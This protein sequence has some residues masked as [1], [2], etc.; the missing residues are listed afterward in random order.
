MDYSVDKNIKIG[1]SKF[2]IKD[3]RKQIAALTEP[4]L[5]KFI[6]TWACWSVARKSFGDCG[7]VTLS[8]LLRQKSTRGGGELTEIQVDVVTSYV[9]SL[10]QAGTLQRWLLASQEAKKPFGPKLADLCK[11]NAMAVEAKSWPAEVDSTNVDAIVDAI[12]EC[13]RPVNKR[14]SSSDF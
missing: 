11:A 14:T 9:T 6:D 12:L 13:F 4:E 1:I 3:V 5:R 10:F 7:E 8:E 2:I